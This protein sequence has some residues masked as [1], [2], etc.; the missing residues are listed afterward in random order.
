MSARPL[1]DPG[2]ATGN[3]REREQIALDHLTYMHPKGVRSIDLGRAIH[4][5][6]GC[7]YC[8]ET[9]L[10]KYAMS[11]GEE[12]GKQ[13]RARDLAIK[14]RTGYW[15]LTRPPVTGHNP[16]TAEIPF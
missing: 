6:R 13:L 4:L 5:A 12:V 2:P 7:P 1:F 11:T 9:R 15:Q 16:A 10:C 8:S 14:R 3:L